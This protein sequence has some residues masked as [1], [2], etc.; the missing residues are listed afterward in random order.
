MV[1]HRVEDRLEDLEAIEAPEAGTITALGDIAVSRDYDAG[2]LIATLEAPGGQVHELHN[3]QGGSQDDLKKTFEIVPNGIIAGDW[4]LKVADTY[5]QDLGEC[6]EA[7]H[8]S[9][10][11]N[12]TAFNGDGVGYEGDERERAEEEYAGQHGHSGLRVCVRR[13]ADDRAGE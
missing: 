5:A 6:I 1:S 9:Y 2:T 4:T 10:L 7:T 3:K 11:L 8:A 13:C 12:Y